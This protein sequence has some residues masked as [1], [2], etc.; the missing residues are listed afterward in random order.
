MAGKTELVTQTQS[1]Q[2]IS[3][4][5]IEPQTISTQVEVA[6]VPLQEFGSA[7]ERI[8]YALGW[9]GY[10]IVPNFQVLWLSDAVTQSHVI[11]PS[12]VGVTALYGLLYILAA[13]SLATLL[14][15]RREVG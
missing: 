14:F 6:T 1:P 4:G 8:A 15:Q 2:I 10:A 7:G 11:P 3:H 5:N 9:V 13:L 12:H